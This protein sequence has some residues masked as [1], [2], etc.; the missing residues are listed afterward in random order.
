MRS[1]V[2]AAGSAEWSEGGADS[3]LL[4]GEKGIGMEAV[5][6]ADSDEDR[7]RVR[8]VWSASAVLMAV[9]S[10]VVADSRARWAEND[11]G[12]GRGD[13]ALYLLPLL[14]LLL[15][16][17]CCRPSRCCGRLSAVLSLLT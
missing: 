6:D 4:L 11:V 12:S 8:L 2:R 17:G 15:A 3:G 9:D 16:R 7:R 14:P 5:C 13:G 10:A 1:V